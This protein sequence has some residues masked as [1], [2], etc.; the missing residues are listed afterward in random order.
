LRTFGNMVLV[1]QKVVNAPDRVQQ[2]RAARAKAQQAQ[3][4]K[5][6]AMQ[7]AAGAVEGAKTLSETE[8]GGGMNALQAMLSGGVAA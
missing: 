2:L 8:M 1:P 3:A 4:A 7:M 6:E 5:E